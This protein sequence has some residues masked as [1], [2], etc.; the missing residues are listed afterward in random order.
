MD[1]KGFDDL[2][3]RLVTQRSRRSVL[4]GL[5]GGSAALVAAKAGASLAAP[6]DKVTICHWSEDLGTFEPISVS[7]NAVDA[8]LAHGDQICGE[9]QVCT[10]DGCG[11]AC[12]GVTIDANN[13][14]P[15]DTGFFLAAGESV[16]VSV[17]GISAW[18]PV[19]CEVDADGSGPCDGGVGDA[20]PFSCGSVVGAVGGGNIF[21]NYALFTQLGSNP[22]VITASSAGNLVLQ[23]VDGCSFCYGDNYGSL[24]VAIC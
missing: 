1:G 14:S 10:A 17:T 2:T 21:P 23:Y 24:E 3:R 12:F 19:G 18:C 22:T 11:S 5:V 16:T 8:H 4:R 9:G 7:G 15:V 13:G 20:T 6:E